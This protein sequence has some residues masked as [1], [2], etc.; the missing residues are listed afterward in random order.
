MEDLNNKLAGLRATVKKIKKEIKSFEENETKNVKK[1]TNTLANNIFRPS[2]YSKKVSFNKLNKKLMKNYFKLSLKEK[3]FHQNKRNT[4][5]NENNNKFKEK[6][7]PAP[8]K[9]NKNTNTPQ[10]R[11]ITKN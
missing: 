3:N 1:R 2:S 4:I 8:Q 5:G 7:T 10:I 6:M 9:I 11:D